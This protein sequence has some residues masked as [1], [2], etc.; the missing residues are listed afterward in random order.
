M[1][2]RQQG[3]MAKNNV[4]NSIDGF[5]RLLDIL[6]PIY[7]Q[8]IKDRTKSAFN[9][10]YLKNAED[11]P[12]MVQLLNKQ[13]TGNTC[14]EFF[15]RN[16]TA[17]LQ[18]VVLVHY[19]KLDG[20]HTFAIMEPVYK[21]QSR[22]G[23]YPSAILTN[24]IIKAIK[25]GSSAENYEKT[26]IY[27]LTN[28]IQK[29]TRGCVEIAFIIAEEAASNT[30]KFIADISK[31][32]RNFYD[33]QLECHKQDSNMAI[34]DKNVFAINLESLQKARPIFNQMKAANQ[35]WDVIP[36]T[37]IMS[38]RKEIAT[39]LPDN[40]SVYSF[41]NLPKILA[42]RTGKTLWEKN[43]NGE[44]PPLFKCIEMNSS[45]T[46]ISIQLNAPYPGFEETLS[47]MFPK[48]VKL[49]TDKTTVYLPINITAEQLNAAQSNIPN[50]S[51][52]LNSCQ[53]FYVKNYGNQT[54]VINEFHKR[55]EDLYGKPVTEE[56][57]KQAKESLKSIP[58]NAVG[59]ALD[60]TQMPGA[61]TILTNKF[62]MPKDK[63]ISALPDMHPDNN[64]TMR[65]ALGAL[66]K[67]L[68]QSKAQ[69][70]AITD[71]GRGGK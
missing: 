48:Q 34:K 5:G 26:E 62:L 54:N 21:T 70:V 59:L 71:T 16:K 64:H 40:E 23:V 27:A 25:N 3:L 66:S 30:K 55:Y 38:K 15:I 6:L 31:D 60:G 33:E 61:N 18:H 52:I 14:A 42:D 56:I 63:E 46:F 69:D 36:N 10:F 57:T 58:E 65:S 39:C 37:Y 1:D 50:Y 32:R 44:L 19:Q 9:A 11:L 67:F 7:A 8:K 17:H 29:S 28:H 45:K 49:S 43:H 35:E 53:L 22:D 24:N 47:K 4:P 13:V 41:E 51:S 2:E 20:N 12:F 68:E